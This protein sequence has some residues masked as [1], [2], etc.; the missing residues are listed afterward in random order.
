[1]GYLDRER[2]LSHTRGAYNREQLSVGDPT[3]K[4]PRVVL[5]ANHA[6]TRWKAEV[7]A[8]MRISL[9]FFRLARGR[10][11]GRFAVCAWRRLNRR[12]E[13][14]THP[15]LCG[16]ITRAILTVAQDLAEIGHVEPETALLHDHVRPHTLQ[17]LMFGQHPAGLLHERDEQVERAPADVDW[18]TVPGK[19]S[20]ARRERE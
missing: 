9:Q 11:G 13:C 8:R 15:D 14:V 12:D 2:C 18:R 20:L 5:A 17:K 19:E 3:L 4:Q 1:M 7:S 6:R 10:G 16:D